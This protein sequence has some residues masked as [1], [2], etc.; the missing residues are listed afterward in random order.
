MDQVPKRLEASGKMNSAREISR[1][2]LSSVKENK[3]FSLCG[4][5][6]IPRFRYI[7]SNNGEWTYKSRGYA[8]CPSLVELTKDK[9][10]GVKRKDFAKVS[11]TPSFNTS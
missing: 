5:V 11:F 2:A 1:Y 9:Y 3:L 7:I 4:C 6:R 8:T 10:P